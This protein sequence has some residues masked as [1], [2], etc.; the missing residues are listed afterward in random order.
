[1]NGVY[2]KMS[3]PTKMAGDNKDKGEATDVLGVMVVAVPV[4]RTA[5][6]VL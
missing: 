3:G 2:D 6:W 1:M 5:V 4:L